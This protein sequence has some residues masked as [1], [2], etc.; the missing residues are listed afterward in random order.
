[1]RIYAPS[2]PRRRARIR[3][4]LFC[5][6]IP[7]ARPAL[8]EMRLHLLKGV[9]GSLLR[10]LDLLDP[11]SGPLHVAGDRFLEER[12]KAEFAIV[13][14]FAQGP[15]LVRAEFDGDFLGHGTPLLPWHQ[16]RQING[17]SASQCCT[18]ARSTDGGGDAP[19]SPARQPHAGPCAQ[20]QNLRDP[21]GYPQ[22]IAAP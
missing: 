5:R 17:P 18:S 6:L 21:R 10:L 13:R 11:L 1:M 7:I 4:P 14:P 19:P 16:R 15:H 9:E 20:P 3:E 2:P 12:L 22:E 8:S